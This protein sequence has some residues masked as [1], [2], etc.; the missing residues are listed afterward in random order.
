ME[1]LEELWKEF[2]DGHKNIILRITDDAQKK[3]SYFSE[4]VSGKFEELYIQ[5]KSSLKG[6]LQPFLQLVSQ[7]TTDFD[8]SSTV[9]DIQKSINN[10]I[11][12]PTIQ[13]PTFNGK[14][15]EWQ[16]FYDL[17]SSIIHNNN[18]LSQV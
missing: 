14:Y 13:L 2:K 7:Q 16:T 9:R 18:C 4:D 1:L 5:F 12:L 6:K 11:K 3:V 17:F 10:E 8:S 15:E